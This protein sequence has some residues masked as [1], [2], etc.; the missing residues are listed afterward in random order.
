MTRALA[1]LL[2]ASALVAQAPQ[3]DALI[4]KMLEVHTERGYRIRATLTATSGGQ[5]KAARQLLILGRRERAGT[6]TFYQQLWPEERGGRALVIVPAGPHQLNGFIHRAGR[7]TP[8][9]DRLQGAAFFDSTFTLEDV[10]ERFWEWPL[11]TRTGEESI[12]EYRCTIVDV[13]PAPGTATQY[14]FMRAWIAPDIAM[15][16]R[17]DEFGKDGKLVKRIELF[18]PARLED[19]WVPTL[20]TV[21]SPD[22]RS[23]SVIEG[24]KEDPDPT[25]TRA[26]FTIASVARRLA[27][28]AR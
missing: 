13:R 15:A 12:G 2:A 25:L 4:A 26:D 7:V 5:M 1:A 21:E 19:R 17:V 6:W 23:R 10:A 24:S 11:R 18:R 3:A 22:R 9:S 14:G 27:R 8:L 28:T 20:V 16:L